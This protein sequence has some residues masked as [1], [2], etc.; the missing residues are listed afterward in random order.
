M[1]KLRNR[2]GRQAL[3]KPREWLSHGAQQL[4]ENQRVAAL[5]Q[6]LKRSFAGRVTQNYLSDDV[7]GLAAMLAYNALFSLMPVLMAIGIVI[8]VVVQDDS[9]R[10]ELSSI[11]TEE[12]PQSLSEP[13]ASWIDTASSDLRSVGLV[14]VITLLY[15][16]SRLYG[17]LDRCFAVVYRSERHGY[18]ERKFWA[19]LVA[20]ALAMVLVFATAISALAT[21]LFG[22][23]L[24]KY[25]DIDPT[26]EEF[27][28]VYVLAFLLGFAMSLVA[29][30]AIPRNGSGW[31]GS[32]PGAA[33][34]GL[35]FVLLSQLYPIYIS[36]TGGFSAYGAVFGLGLLFMFWLY[37]AA[38]III[39]GAEICA[40]T[41]GA[42]ERNEQRANG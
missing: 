1:P 19:L 7:D 9:R 27:L 25:L 32:M 42:R 22:T 20:P 38:Q 2:L 13:V 8:G 15:G 30:G 10:D 39:I 34:A 37:L 29:Y 36:L 12:L 21:G 33:V 14:T 40:A 31:R 28:S 24:A 16:G 3:G 41:S 35:L 4:A 26:V 18:I 6:R 5:R 17:G 23:P 11:V